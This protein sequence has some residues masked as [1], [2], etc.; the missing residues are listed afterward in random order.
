MSTATL[1]RV[2][3][4]GTP[5]DRYF[6]VCAFFDS[7]DQEYSV[8]ESYYKEGLANGEKTLHIVDPKLRDDHRNRLGRMGDVVACEDCG[9]LEGVTPAETYLQGGTFVPE[10]ML[11]TVDAVIA[12]ARERGFPRTRIMGNMNWALDDGP[13]SERLIEYE[14]LVNEVL[15]RT[16]QP[17]ICV[18]DTSL[19]TGAMMLDILRTH[20]LTLVNGAVQANPFFTPPEVFLEEL[21]KRRRPRASA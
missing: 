9:Q 18:Y 10:K 17:A 20:P 6:H 19:L 3:I 2:E 1:K 13:S 8:L 14:A 21:Q 15:T 4:A 12:A 11:V 16:R 7:R 5:L